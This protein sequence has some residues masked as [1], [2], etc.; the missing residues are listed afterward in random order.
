MSV[1]LCLYACTAVEKMLD[2]DFLP[3]DNESITFLCRRVSFYLHVFSAFELS[4]VPEEIF[5][6][7]VF[8]TKS[9]L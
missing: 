9:S 2:I 7:G 4:L 6:V 5:S 8:H 3:E 1:T